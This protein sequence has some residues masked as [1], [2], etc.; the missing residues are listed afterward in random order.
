M[1]IARRRA[2]AGDQAAATSVAPNRSPSSAP[3]PS[4]AAA[5]GAL[6]GARRHAPRLI[7]DR[8]KPPARAEHQRASGRIGAVWPHYS[9]PV[10]TSTMT[11]TRL[12]SATRSLAT[13]L[14]SRSRGD[15]TSPGRVIA[16]LKRAVPGRGEG[17]AGGS[18][19]APA[20]PTEAA[21][22]RPPQEWRGRASM[23]SWRRGSTPPRSAPVD[24]DTE[25]TEREADTA[26]SRSRTG[27]R[28]RR[29]PSP[30]TS[31]KTAPR[32]KCRSRPG[33]RSRR[34]RRSAR[35]EQRGRQR[36]ARGRRRRGAGASREHHAMDTTRRR[37]LGS[38]PCTMAS[39]SVSSRTCSRPRPL[40]DYRR[41]R[42]ASV[43]R[44]QSAATRHGQDNVE[45]PTRGQEPVAGS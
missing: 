32:G 43:R 8:A 31:P 25:T 9:R 20:S 40:G 7:V 12:V 33:V 13:R 15:T 16:R 45:G 34:R 26:S 41:P 38:G 17:K 39:A 10:V 30:G 28:A 42:P 44:R 5:P 24:A 21:R 37:G 18:Y 23:V 11:A 6:H 19:D 4:E 14:R 27:P 22:I 2:R 1:T 36:E 3:A 35:T 29:G